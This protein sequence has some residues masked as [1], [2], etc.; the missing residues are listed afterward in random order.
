MQVGALL[1]EVFFAKANFKLREQVE[2]RFFVV[3]CIL[4]LLWRFSLPFLGN[5]LTLL[6]ARDLDTEVSCPPGACT[7]I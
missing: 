3:E 5:R 4:N 6:V 7:G 1:G 2:Q